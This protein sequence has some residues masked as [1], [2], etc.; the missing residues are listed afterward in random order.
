MIRLPSRRALAL[1]APTILAL[2]LFALPAFAQQK[3]APAAP[4]ASTQAAQPAPPAW[5]QLSNADRETL[6]APLR[7]RWNSADADKRQH[8]LAHAR[9][10]RTMTPEQ[11]RAAHDGMKR[12]SNLSPEQRDHA[13]ALF[14]QMRTMDP[15]QRRALREQW[16]SMT[17]EQRQAWIDAHP[18]PPNAQPR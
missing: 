16:R 14:Q 13:R 11:R 17:P 10:W 7:D 2:V 8:M 18:V 9:E 3:P 4:P 1:H 5:E 15:D 6:I 12:W